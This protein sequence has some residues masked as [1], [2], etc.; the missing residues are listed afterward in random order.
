[1]AIVVESDVAFHLPNRVKRDGLHHDQQI[2]DVESDDACHLTLV[3]NVTACTMMQKLWMNIN[4]FIPLCAV[5]SVA[6][7]SSNSGDPSC[8][9]T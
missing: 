5:S 8:R 1:M 7:F 2:V 6:L 9:R 3:S 4:D